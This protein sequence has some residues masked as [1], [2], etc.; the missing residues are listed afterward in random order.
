[1]SSVNGQ[2]GGNNCFMVGMAQLASAP[3]C[4][5]GGR[6]FESLYPPSFVFIRQKINGRGS[7]MLGYR[8]AVRHST[9]TDALA[10]SNPASPV[11][12]LLD[13][14]MWDISSGGR[15]LDF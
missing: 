3:D 4:G 2:T 8:Q 11:K 15:A 5:S 6:G 9:L 1:M 7:L 12:V 10:G 13:F 14:I